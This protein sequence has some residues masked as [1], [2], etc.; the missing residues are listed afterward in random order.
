VAT[1]LTQITFKTM[2][3]TISMTKQEGKRR[4]VDTMTIAK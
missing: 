2:E 4:N 1:L 3:D